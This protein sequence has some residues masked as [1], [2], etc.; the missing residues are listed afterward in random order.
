MKYNREAGDDGLFSAYIDTFMK[1][2]QE[3]DGWPVGVTSDEEK[4]KYIDDYYQ[5]EGIR[6]DH[7]NIAKNSNMRQLAKLMLNSFWGKVKY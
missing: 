5:H 4:Q 7:D 6:L 2:K 1:M 3:A